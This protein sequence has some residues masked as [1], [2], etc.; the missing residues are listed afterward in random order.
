MIL[1]QWQL[2]ILLGLTSSCFEQFT[3][4]LVCMWSVGGCNHCSKQSEP[5]ST[6]AHLR[7]WPTQHELGGKRTILLI[8]I[9]LL[10]P[11]PCGRQAKSPHMSR[12]KHLS[13]LFTFSPRFVALQIDFFLII[14]VRIYEEKPLSCLQSWLN[15]SPTLGGR[16][17]WSNRFEA[18]GIFKIWTFRNWS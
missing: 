7:W 18:E 3:M 8:K 6:I 15:L 14:R 2:L 9:V 16:D 13:L 10:I 5:N 11:H 17:L 1:C 12:R 4:S